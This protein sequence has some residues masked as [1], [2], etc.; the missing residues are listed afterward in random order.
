MKSLWI[1]TGYCFLNQQYHRDCFALAQQGTVHEELGE[2]RS[3]I[4]SDHL[5]PSRQELMILW[6]FLT[7]TRF[8]DQIGPLEVED[9]DGDRKFTDVRAEWT[10]AGNPTIDTTGEQMQMAAAIGFAA[11]DVKFRDALLAAV[12]LVAVR[13]VLLNHE[14]EWGRFVLETGEPAQLHA[15]LA[16]LQPMGLDNPLE[17]FH[18]KAWIQ[19]RKSACPTGATTDSDAGF[20]F[21]SHSAFLRQYL[22]YEAPENKERAERLVALLRETGVLVEKG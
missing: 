1:A 7:R 17:I 9:P 19:P 15:F 6:E 11:L 22:G 21:L 8:D 2:L 16:R 20:A 5:T 14:A 10:A 18:Q 4:F 12:D 13:D 3:K